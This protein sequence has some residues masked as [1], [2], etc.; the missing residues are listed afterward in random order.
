MEETLKQQIREAISKTG[1][2]LEH[3]IDG[4]LKQHGWQTITNR[5]YIDDIKGVEREIDILAYKVY[6]DYTE[7]IQYVTTLIISCKKS[8]YSKWCFLTRKADPNDSATDWTPYHF[9]TND[10]ILSF[11]SKKHRDNIT[12]VYLCHR[13]VKHLFNFSE[14]VF[15]YQQLSKSVTKNDCKLKGEWYVNGNTHIYDSIIT[16]IK[17]LDIEKMSRLDKSQQIDCKRYYTFHLIS[18]FDGDMLQASFDDEGN[19]DIK[20]ISQIKYLNRHI[21]NKIDN[22]YIVNFIKKEIFNYRLTLF[23]YLH[24]ENCKTLPKLVSKFYKE[25][26]CDPEKLKLVWNKV[27]DIIKTHIKYV[28]YDVGYTEQ[29]MKSISLYPELRNDILEIEVWGLMLSSQETILRL[30]N[31]EGLYDVISRYL[32]L[33]LRYSGNFKFVEP[34]FDFEQS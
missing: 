24:E 8:D 10:K 6:S 7:N 2:P 9:C 20:E 14:R 16:T 23:D 11:M 30:N 28:L 26:F 29:N 32:S 13:G 33:Y 27:E 34:L 5:H 1:F 17:A 25:I 15:A 21:V 4:V 18:V 22:F 19:V 3:Y 31:N 12:S